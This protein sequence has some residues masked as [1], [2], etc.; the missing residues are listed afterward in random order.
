MKVQG[1]PNGEYF[2][3]LE[4]PRGEVIYY[5]RGNGVQISGTKCG[6]GRQPLPT[7]RLLKILPGSELADVPPPDSDDRSLHQL[8][9]GD[10]HD[11]FTVCRN[12]FPESHFPA[13]LPGWYTGSG[14]GPFERHPWPYRN[15]DRCLHISVDCANANV[16]PG[17]DPGDKGGKRM[18]HRAAPLHSVQQLCG[19]LSQKMSDDGSAIYAAFDRAGSRY[20]SCMSTRLLNRL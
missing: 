10:A 3:R 4:Q 12:C 6:S 11:H 17:G 18:D 7:C 15:C 1:T 2:A 5:T 20:F 14:S 13:G 9:R 8:Y 19:S 16:R